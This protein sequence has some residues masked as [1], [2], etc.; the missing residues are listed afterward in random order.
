MECKAQ[1][2]VVYTRR[3]NF[4]L[5]FLQNI[6][7]NKGIRTNIK[8]NENPCMDLCES[9]FFSFRNKSSGRTFLHVNPTHNQSAI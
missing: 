6:G 3:K 2:D 5:R 7:N 9:P 8:T 4:N 1:V